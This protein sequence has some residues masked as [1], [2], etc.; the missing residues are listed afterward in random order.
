MVH[1]TSFA[2]RH[3]ANI[4][5]RIELPPDGLPRAFVLL[6]HC[7]TCSK[8]LTAHRRIARVL[9]GAD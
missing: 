7:F 6:A 5:A 2:N 8:D 3:G 4:S 1:N 9:T